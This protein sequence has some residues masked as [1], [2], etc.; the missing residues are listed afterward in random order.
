MERND[1]KKFL[2]FL[3]SLFMNQKDI[4]ERISS[5]WK[6]HSIFQKTLDQ[7]SDMFQSSTYDGPPFASGTPH[8]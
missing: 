5:Y 6:D 7:R 1:N 2:Y 3:F 8:F 4:I